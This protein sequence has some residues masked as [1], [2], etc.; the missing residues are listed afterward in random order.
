MSD[1]CSL[2]ENFVLMIWHAVFFVD[3]MVSDSMHVRLSHFSLVFKVG[4]IM[5]VWLCNV[6][7]VFKVTGIRSIMMCAR[8][9]SYSLAFNVA[10]VMKY[11]GPHNLSLVVTCYKDSSL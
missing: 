11:V 5:C 3:S 9:C 1:Y 6:N 10:N 4:S 2:F 8:L 7:L